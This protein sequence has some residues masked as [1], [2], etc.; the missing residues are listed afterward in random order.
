MK[1]YLFAAL[2]IVGLALVLAPPQAFAQEEKPFTVHGEVRMRGEYD[3]NATD[4][5][6]SNFGNA[7]PLIPNDG[8]MFWPYRVRIAVEGKFT[9][10]VEGYIEVQGDGTWGGDSSY[11]V[12]A[13]GAPNN[14]TPRWSGN[15]AF[16]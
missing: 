12:G 7:N 13:F 4:F 16:R 2:L 15:G 8:E 3:N 9:K 14:Q 6:N 10:N 1:K 11:L 5:S